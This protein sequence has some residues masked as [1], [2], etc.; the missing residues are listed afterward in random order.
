MMM[1]FVPESSAKERSYLRIHPGV[2]GNFF[3]IAGV[4]IGCLAI[5]NLAG[6]WWG[7]LAGAIAILVAA[8]L[9]YGEVGA[10][11]P[12]PHRPTLKIAPIHGL[13]EFLRTRRA[14]FTLS[15]RIW[16]RLHAK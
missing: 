13:S 8:E 12:L 7:L 3:E 10:K 4:T 9:I 11:I 1:P 15:A 6:P 5:A 14:R 2:I 16:W